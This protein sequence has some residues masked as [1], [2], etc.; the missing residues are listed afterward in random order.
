M[1]SSRTPEDANRP[2]SRRLTMHN[3]FLTDSY[4]NVPRPGSQALLQQA[5]NETARWKRFAS[6]LKR[7]RDQA[8][9]HILELETALEINEAKLERSLSHFRS[10]HNFDPQVHQVV[11]N[12]YVTR[13]ER[14]QNTIKSL[15]KEINEKTN[16]HDSVV[17]L[18]QQA[19]QELDEIKSSKKSLIVDDDAMTGKWKQL[20]FIIRNLSTSFLHRITPFS[21]NSI[22]DE[23]LERYRRLMP[24]TTK[25]KLN[26]LCQILIWDFI[27]TRVLLEPIT[28]WGQDIS[29]PTMKLFAAIVKDWPNG[30][31]ISASDYHA[32]RAQ[33]GEIINTATNVDVTI[34]DNLKAELKA[35]L[36]PFT[37]PEN[38]KEVSRQSDNII[39]K[40]VDLAIIF[41]RARCFYYLEP[42]DRDSEL[43]FDANTMDNVD[44]DEGEDSSVISIISPALLKDGNS[45]GENYGE[46]IVLAKAVVWCE[47]MA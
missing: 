22:A 39:D 36:R 24:I 23:I 44:G 38:A 14:A 25:N 13:A 8:K 32:F 37:S 43:L 45:K 41:L 15:K 31:K 16:E 6:L 34:C 20:Q 26:H 18:W 30:D 17:S 47:E 19:L 27:T 1:A 42:T 12:S 40:A 5:N 4:A 33:T 29:D 9:V 10:L 11:P 3:R 21:I 28:V 46:S 2:Y 7:E 35:Q